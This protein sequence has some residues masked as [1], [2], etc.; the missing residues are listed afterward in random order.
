MDNKRKIQILDK[1]IDRLRKQKQEVVKEI[2]IAQIK[3][4]DSKKLAGWNAFIF[5]STYYGN[6]IGEGDTQIIYIFAPH[7]NIEQWKNVEFSHGDSTESQSN[8]RFD[9]FIDSLDKGDYECCI[10][11]DIIQVVW[12][13]LYKKM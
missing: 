5:N 2:K 12:P 3:E 10:D 9:E 13:E 8:K 6:E 1:A 7:I 11:K 4:W